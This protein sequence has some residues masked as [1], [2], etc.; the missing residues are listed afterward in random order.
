MIIQNVAIGALVD[1][2]GRVL[3]TRRSE[4]N[5]IMPNFWEFPGGKILT[6]SLIHI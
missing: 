1:P 6:L 2:E 3:L 4:R 5:S